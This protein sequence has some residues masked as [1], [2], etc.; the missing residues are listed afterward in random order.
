ME[1]SLKHLHKYWIA[2]HIH[3]SYMLKI[4][5]IEKQY[6]VMKSNEKVHNIIKLLYSY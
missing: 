2:C 1:L 5:K 4:K 6:A 3:L